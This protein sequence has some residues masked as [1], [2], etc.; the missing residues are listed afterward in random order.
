MSRTRR[1]IRLAVAAA[2]FAVATV[3]LP[4][5]PAQAQATHVAFYVAGVGTACTSVGANSLT[6]LESKYDVSIGPA[7]RPTAGMVLFIDGHG[8]NT[9]NPDYWSYWHWSNGRWAY[10][11]TGPSAYHPTAGQSEGW[12]FGAYK[13]TDQPPLPGA[14]YA[15]LCGGQDPVSVPVHSNPAPPPPVHR[16]SEPPVNAPTGPGT[17][18]HPRSASGGSTKPKPPSTTSARPSTHSAARSGGSPSLTPSPS[19]SAIGS[20]AATAAAANGLPT[21]PPKA[22]PAKRSGIPPWG[23]ALG[24]VAVAALGGVAVWRARAQRHNQL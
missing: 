16:T 6:D 12:A 10:A 2:L 15:A 3:G 21:A 18:S 7:G 1:P 8:S 4:S 22:A 13:S 19:S 9:N 20:L 11:G 17:T 24:I 23:T 5:P 14:N